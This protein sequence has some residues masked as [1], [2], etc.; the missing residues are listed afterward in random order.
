[1]TRLSLAVL[2]DLLV[3]WILL[4]MAMRHIHNAWLADLAAVPQTLLALWTLTGLSPRTATVRLATI[5]GMAALGFAV[6]E[7][8]LLGLERK[9]LATMTVSSAGIFILSF[10]SLWN[11][12]RVV[13]E[14]PHF[15]NPA[16][17]ILA[18]WVID[19]G[20]ILVFYP[21]SDN[22]LH[23]LPHDWILVPWFLNYLV[24]L[25]LSLS[26]SWTFLCR[27]STSS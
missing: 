19:H 12:L 26:L 20:T 22:F 11:L 9:W 15:R 5:T 21:I 14:I 1:M 13:D 4:G 2:F 25:L 10:W 27:K 23:H 16:F 24:G 8:T 6:W 17:W 3:N 18:T 7:G